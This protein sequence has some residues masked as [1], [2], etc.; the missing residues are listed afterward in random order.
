MKVTKLEI[1]QLHKLIELCKKGYPEYST[2]TYED[3]ESPIIIF[4]NENREKRIHWFELCCNQLTRALYKYLWDDLIGHEHFC[5]SVLLN[6]LYK[7][8]NPIDYLYDEVRKIE[9]AKA[10]GYSPGKT[11]DTSSK[12][13]Q[14]NVYLTKT[15]PKKASVIR[16]LKDIAGIELRL[17]KQ[18]VDSVYK[19][20]GKICIKGEVYLEEANRIKDNLI[21]IGA[22]VKI[23]TC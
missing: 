7:K 14:Y 23:E 19:Y 13:V 16:T 10:S 3:K 15:G 18:M 22:N 9:I 21:S 6:F 17:G 5:T 1:D 2:I 12:E 8:I 20:S 11:L 4:K